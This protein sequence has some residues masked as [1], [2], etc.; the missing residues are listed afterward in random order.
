M[1]PIM[2]FSGIEL[3]IRGG[4]QGR[5]EEVAFAASLRVRPAAASSLLGGLLLLSC[6]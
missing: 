2:R 3:M 4:I 1:Q 6:P 5:K